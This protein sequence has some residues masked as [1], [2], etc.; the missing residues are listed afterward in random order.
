[1]ALPSPKIDPEYAA[2]VAVLKRAVELDSEF[3]YLQALA[4]YEKGMDMLLQVLKGTKEDTKRCNLR[5]KITEYMDRAEHLKR[6]LDQEKEDG[7]YHKQIKI[8]ENATGFSYESLFQE[9]LTETITEVWIED[10]Y[11]RNTQQLY[12][13]L[14]FCEMLIK[15]PCKVKTIHLLTSLDQDSGRTEQVSALNEIEGS[16]RTH[17]VSLEVKY[18]S[19][20]HDREI[21]LPA[22]PLLLES[23]SV[24]IGHLL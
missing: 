18:S 14:R 13:F 21:S 9:Y 5:K 11:I 22:F 24:H 23:D 8:E 2:A 15:S 3:R 6:Y 17:G 4:F 19:S 20:I 10:P 7:K 12:N 1:M 16:L